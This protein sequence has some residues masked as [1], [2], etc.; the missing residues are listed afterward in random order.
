MI[1]RQGL[2]EQRDEPEHT[3]VASAQQNDRPGEGGVRDSRGEL[4]RIFALAESPGVFNDELIATLSDFVTVV[5]ASRERIAQLSTRLAER[6]ALVSVLEAKYAALE[7]RLSNSTDAS[8]ANAHPPKP[9]V[10]VVGD[11]AKNDGIWHRLKNLEH[12]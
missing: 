3:P 8:T 4:S 9:T 2:A 7:A 12:R 10:A 11:S 5:R 6:D 1:A